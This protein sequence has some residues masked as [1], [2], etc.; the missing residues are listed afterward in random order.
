M[1]YNVEFKLNT[2]LFYISWCHS[3]GTTMYRHSVTD[4]EYFPVLLH[5]DISCTQ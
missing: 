4:K 3:D 5:I 1:L 2:T